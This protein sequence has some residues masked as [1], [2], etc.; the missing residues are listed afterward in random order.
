MRDSS[1]I[2]KRPNENILTNSRSKVSIQKSA[3]KSGRGSYTDLAINNDF[4]VD[5]QKC[6][7]PQQQTNNANSRVSYLR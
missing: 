1:P 7:S 3:K 4:S 2:D 6:R 5:K